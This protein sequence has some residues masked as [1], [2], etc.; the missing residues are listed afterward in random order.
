LTG[1]IGTPAE[2]PRSIDF[3]EA[4]TPPSGRPGWVVIATLAEGVHVLPSILGRGPSA[5]HQARIL[6][7]ACQPIALRDGPLDEPT[8]AH[9]EPGWPGAEIHRA[10]A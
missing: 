10:L 5:G 3:G 1:G 8:W 4:G 7:P 2:D 6:C 9:D